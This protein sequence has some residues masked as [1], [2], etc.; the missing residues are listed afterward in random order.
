MGLIDTLLTRAAADPQRIVL[1]EA[2]DARILKLAAAAAE[3][4]V[5]RPILLGDPAGIAA[6]AEG[7]GISLTEVLV[8]DS[9]SDV[10]R[11]EVA[12]SYLGVTDRLSEKAVARK[13]KDP[14]NMACALVMAGSA[15]AVAAGVAHSTAEVILAAQTMIGLSEGTTV[16]SSM[17]FLE[18]P[19]WTGSEGNL[20]AI[21]DCAVN[22][23]PSPRELA[24]I[25]ASTA[26]TIEALVGWEPRV[27]MLSFSTDGSGEHPIVAKVSEAV[28]IARELYP[29]Y[30]ID[31]EFQLD[32][33]LRPEIAAKKVRRESPVAG[34]ANALIFPD[35]N[36]GNIGVKLVQQFA[37]ATAPGPVLQGFNRPITDFSRSAPVEEMLGAVAMVAVLA[38]NAGQR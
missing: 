33:A 11:S 28:A 19:G 22:A 16:V 29:Q 3:R 6:L 17:G 31:G 21:A 4:G 30:A 20:V 14:L 37:G 24:D 36:A 9:T 32:A 13:I 35:L 10:L 8:L 23:E 18:V 1:P 34:R 15:D 26:R 5:A 38:Q 12:A 7:E 27:A 2:D 25:A